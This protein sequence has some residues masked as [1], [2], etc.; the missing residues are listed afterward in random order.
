MRVTRIRRDAIVHRP[1]PTLAALA[2]LVV[3]GRT[4]TRCRR[5]RGWTRRPAAAQGPIAGPSITY[6]S[7]EGSDV[8][9][10]LYSAADG[11]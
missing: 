7:Y 10:V 1:W 3:L 2:V 6:A 4:W 8:D 11:S 5:G 9:D